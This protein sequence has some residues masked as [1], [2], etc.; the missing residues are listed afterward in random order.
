MYEEYGA[1][2]C[3]VRGVCVHL[4]AGVSV[5]HW[6]ERVKNAYEEKCVENEEM[7]RKHCAALL[8]Q[9]E[10]D[11]DPVESYM[12]PGG[13]QQFKE[14]LNN[15]LQL[16]RNKPAKGVKA[17]EA[18]DN[19]L[20]EK[21]RLG[22]IIL[23]TDETMSEQQRHLK[24]QRAQ[25]EEEKQRAAAAREQQMALVIRTNDIERARQENERQLME[26]MEMDREEFQRNNQ[27]LRMQLVRLAERPTRI[28]ERIET[29]ERIV[30]RTTCVVS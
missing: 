30:E 25:L 2:L 13:Y 14:H 23:T 12:K 10:D 3:F 24:E 5:C 4:P 7:S 28:I 15:L 6:Q 18:L 22:K 20:S 21:N 1:D 11:M 8:L 9:L 17:E 29:H 16:Y 27:Q 19:Y 26:K